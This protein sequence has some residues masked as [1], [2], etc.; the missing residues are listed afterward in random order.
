MNR[1]SQQAGIAGRDFCAT[2][3]A[4]GEGAVVDAL[5][6]AS[7]DE[8][9]TWAGQGRAALLAAG[10]T[11]FEPVLVSIAGNAG[12]VAA[13][14]G[15]ISAGGV[16]V[17]VHV[18]A[19]ARTQDNARALSRARFHLHLDRSDSGAVPR[20]ETLCDTPPPPRKLLQGAGMITFTSGSTGQPKGVVLSLARMTAKFNAI[21]QSLD[22]PQGARVALPLQLIFSFGQWVAFLTLLRGGTVHMAERFDAAETAVAMADGRLD[23][24]AAVPTMLRMLPNDA[25]TPR[26]FTILTGGETVDSELRARLFSAWPGVEI[27]S[28]YGLTESGTCDLFYRDRAGLGARDTMGFPAPGIAA[29][30]DPATGELQLRTPFAMLGYLDMPEETAATLPDGWL[31]TGDLAEPLPDG[32]FRFTGRLKELINRGGNK[33]SPL[34][35]E[36]LF[37]AHPAVKAVLATGVADARLGEAIHLLVVPHAGEA[38]TPEALRDWAKGQTDRFKLP[39]RIHLGAELPLGQTGKADRSALRALIEAGATP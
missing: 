26:R 14:L 27:F 34:E 37:A 16:A 31:R 5:G 28:I 29:R 35:V 18:K 22:M 39:D 13:I 20:L 38:P 2:L 9:R 1:P 19:H 25:A 33:V 11:R 36:S 3:L 6:R 8:I 32:A 4:G 17:P 15:V 30:L 10:L 21:G 24:L 7:M 23:Y 12:D